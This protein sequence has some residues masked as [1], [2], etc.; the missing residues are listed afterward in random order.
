VCWVVSP[1]EERQHQPYRLLSLGSDGLL[2][3]WRC[4]RQGSQ[5]TPVLG[6]RLLA[7]SVPRNLRVGRARGDSVMGGTSLSFSHEDRSLAVVGCENGCLLKC[8]VHTDTHESLDSDLG[9]RSMKSAITFAF[10]PHHGPV[11]GCSCSPFHRNLFLSASTDTSA[12]L[13]SLLDSSPLLCMEPDCGYLFSVQWSPT[14][15]LVFAVGSADGHVIIY[16][17]QASHVKPCAKLDASPHHRPVCSVQYNAK[18]P[19]LL[20]SGDASGIIKV[21]RLCSDLTAQTAGEVDQLA[22]LAMTTPPT[23]SL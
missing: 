2:L 14:R 21:W 12:R 18:R 20:A 23:A 6:Y 16:D 3:V 5:L 22:S 13:Y 8:S 17:L 19:Q 4:P 1:Q 7:E 11:Y 15:P 9:E 10:R